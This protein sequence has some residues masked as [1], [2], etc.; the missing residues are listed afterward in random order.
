MVMRIYSP[1]MALLWDVDSTRN[2]FG[3]GRL[4]AVYTHR[5]YNEV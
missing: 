4:S 5:L 3:L 2:R 1:R